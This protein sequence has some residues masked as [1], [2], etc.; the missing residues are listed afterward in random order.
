MSGFEQQRLELLDWVDELDPLLA[1]RRAVESRRR[2]AAAR[3]RL[4]AGRLTA[5]ICGEFKRGKSTLLNALLAEPDLFPVDTVYATSL[6][7]AASYAER[8]EVEVTLEQA[9][10][11]VL[12]RRIDRAEIAGYATESGNPH[13]TKRARMITVR[14]PNPRLRSGLTLV[15]TPGVGGVHAEHTTVTT[16]FLPGADALLFV[17]DLTQPLTE[18]ELEFLRR[19]SRSARVTGDEDGLLFV[20]TK[21]DVGDCTELAEDART[22]LAEVTGRPRERLRVVAVSAHAKLAYLAHG[23]P[24]DLELS[25][26]E[27][28]ERVIWSALSRRRTTVLLGDALSELDTAVTALITPLQGERAALRG[29]AEQAQQDLREQLRARRRELDRL[30]EA[31][32]WHDRLTTAL[33]GV[34]RELLA[35]AGEELDGLWGDVDSYHLLLDRYLD[36]PQQLVDKLVSDAAAVIGTVNE[37]AVRRTAAV[38]RELVLASELPLAQQRLGGLPPPPVP[39]LEVTGGQQRTD[40]GA[41]GIRATESM[42][43]GTSAGGAL[44]G[45]LGAALGSLLPGIGAAIGGVLG[46]ALGTLFGARNGYRTSMEAS[47]EQ[48]RRQRALALRHELEP[49]RRSQYRHVQEVVDAVLAEFGQALT[50]ELHSRV[51]AAQQSAQEESERVRNAERASQREAAERLAVLEQELAPLLHRRATIADRAAE[52]GRTGE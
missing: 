42:I 36:H 7:I 30:A 51:R 8:E 43:A 15:D 41:E 38:Q 44:G 35:R 5:V 25:N 32:S 23:D 2:L 20:L 48:Q 9:D 14:T 52:Y 49:L 12:R 46:S 3:H 21:A 6:V 45:V 31:G 37:L 24:E 11:S 17:V 50:A 16:G 26:F 22:K 10:G 28:L 40:R 29:S 4:S 39:S 18:S 19:A 27:E 13:N 33:T 34:R 47:R 1:R